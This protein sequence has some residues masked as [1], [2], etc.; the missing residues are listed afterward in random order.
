MELRTACPWETRD[1]RGRG[2]RGNRGFDNIGAAHDGLI[3]QVPR[4]DH[5][6][7]CIHPRTPDLL[8]AIP[9]PPRGSVF[10]NT[11][12][13]IRLSGRRRVLLTCLSPVSVSVSGLPPL[14]S[15]NHSLT[16]GHSMGWPRPL[17][18]IPNII[19]SQPHSGLLWGWPRPSPLLI[20]PDFCHHATPSQ[21]P[22]PSIGWSNLWSSQTIPSPSD[23]GR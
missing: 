17:P 23:R 8:C 19:Q 16:L 21:A 3:S 7:P 13:L 9:T 11:F 22:P 4:Q 10:Q 12:D 18:P 2:L 20:G 15:P 1:H 6:V 5:S 14:T